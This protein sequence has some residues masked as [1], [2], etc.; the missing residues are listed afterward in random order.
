M[1]RKKNTDLSRRDFLRRLGLGAGS[2]MAMMALEPLNI[3]AQKKTD[4]DAVNQKILPLPDRSD[5]DYATRKQ[6]FFESYQRALTDQNT[7]ARSCQDCEE[8]LSKCPQQ[9]RIPNQLA[10]IVQTLRK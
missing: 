9:I 5:A 7:W 1:D 4:K 10:R 8:C 6:Q 3:L 2:A